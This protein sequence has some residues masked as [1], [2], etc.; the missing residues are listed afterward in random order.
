MPNFAGAKILV[1][2]GLRI[3]EWEK[4]LA[5]YHDREVCNFLKYGWP[6]GYHKQDP[7]TSH[8]DNHQSARNYTSA[9]DEFI[10]QESSLGAILGPFPCQPFTPWNRVSPVMTRPKQDTGKRRVIVDKSFPEGQSV[11]DGI[12]ITDFFGQDISYTLPSIKDLVTILHAHGSDAHIWKADLSRAYRQMRADPLDAPLLGIK[13]RD[14]YYI[15]RCPPFGCRSSSAACQRM[16]NAVV[17]MMRSCGFQVLVYLDDYAG[18]EASAERAAAAYRHFTQLA[19]QLG[20]DLAKHKCQPPTQTIDWLGYHVDVR[21]SSIAMPQQKLSEIL[22]ECRKWL[23]KKKANK[24]MIQSLAGSL[25]FI[26][27]CITPARRF[28]SR[29]LM[30]LAGMEDG[31]WTSQLSH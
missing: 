4:R 18:C 3:E 9:V 11:N 5:E 17:F 10:E 30:T 28:I 24:K 22:S 19:D 29:I 25:L 14:Q 21:N 7:P 31:S 15:D 13:V 2:S 20:L 12:S 26:T 1:K 8:E 6:L 27:N 23:E 16:S